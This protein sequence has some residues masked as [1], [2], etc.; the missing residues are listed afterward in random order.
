MIQVAG[1]SRILLIEDDPVVSTIL[2]VALERAGYEVHSARDGEECLDRASR[3]GGRFDLLLSDVVLDGHSAAP[4]LDQLKSLCP[5]T[6]VLMVSGYPLHL[7]VERGYLRPGAVDQ[8]RSFFLQKPFMPAELTA[9][10]DRVLTAHNGFQSE[11]EQKVA[12]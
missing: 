11:I 2:R 9:V 1:K 6:P 7:L 3:H 10:V 4:L 5:A 12:R 8:R